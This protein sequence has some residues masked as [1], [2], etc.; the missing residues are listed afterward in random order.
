LWQKKEGGDGTAPFDLCAVVT[1]PPRRVK[2][3]AAAKTPIH[4]RAEELGVE[5]VWY[6][7]S[8]KD[9]EFLADLESLAPDLCITAAYGQYLPKRFLRTPRL[10][11]LNLH[12]SLLPRWRGAS[13]VQKAL[14]EGDDETGISI[15]YTVTKMDAGPIALQRSIPLHGNET[16]DGLLV[17]LFDW[18]A[19]L[20]IDQVFPRVFT[21][22]LSMETAT[23]QD[24]ALVTKAGLIA[25]ADG[26]LWPHNETAFQMRNKARGYV[27]WPGVRLPVAC[28]GSKKAPPVGCRVK[29]EDVEVISFESLGLD[30]EGSDRPLEELLWVPAR[31]GREAA[32]GVRSAVDP[33]NV[34]LVRKLH[35]PGKNEVSAKLFYK[36]Y[37]KAQPATWLMPEDEARIGQDSIKK[38]KK[39]RQRREA[40]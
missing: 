39:T 21:G 31:N 23:P 9:E 30:G 7:A 25:K 2:K 24:E 37:M 20:L 28:T 1:Q 27:G 17:D 3:K 18:G 4:E 6:P 11:T 15:L 10:G 32:I 33:E 14:V 35:I 13:P 36:G 34:L 38:A 22:D 19:E 5:R 16:A 12:P 40:A 29:V 26:N 8:A